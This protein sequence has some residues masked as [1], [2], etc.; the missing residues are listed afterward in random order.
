MGVGGGDYGEGETGG[1][2]GGDQGGGEAAEDGGDAY[3]VLGGVD[4]DEKR[5]A[6]FLVR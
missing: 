5:P 6:V 2:G 3:E 1:H 4:P